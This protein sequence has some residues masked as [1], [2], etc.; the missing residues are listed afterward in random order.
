MMT[1]NER[2]AGRKPVLSDEQLEQLRRRHQQGE[3]V[4]ALA[5][6]YGISRQALSRHLNSKTMQ[7]E[8]VCYSPAQWRTLNRDFQNIEPERYRLRMDFMYQEEC[9]TSIL[10]DF[11]T[12]EIAVC[13]QTEDVLH[14]AFGLKAKPDW[15]D[16]EAF[17]EE[18]CFPRTRE[19]LP[20]ILEDLGLEFY[21]PLAIVEKTKGR[22]AED[23]QWLRLFYYEKRLAVG[24]KKGEGTCEEYR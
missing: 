4:T 16:F 13:N 10:V 23:L 15:E 22:M 1:R 18:R 8:T 11:R 7:E 20:L 12:R 2:G 9:C 5:Q 14:R 3:T 19:A 24:E 21:D 17:L 6:E